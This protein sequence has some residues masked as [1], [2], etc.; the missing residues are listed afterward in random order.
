MKRFLITYIKINGTKDVFV[1][2][3]KSQF[4][5][6]KK[7]YV[8]GV[9]KDILRIERVTELYNPIYDPMTGWFW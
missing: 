9:D 5:A 6:E 3:A 7:A 4:K 8:E 1:I 2:N